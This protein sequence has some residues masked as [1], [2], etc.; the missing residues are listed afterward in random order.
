[1]YWEHAGIFGK[2]TCV[3]AK[4]EYKNENIW[5]TKDKQFALRKAPQSSYSA[6]GERARRT[7]SELIGITCG[8]EVCVCVCVSVCVCVREIYTCHTRVKSDSP[9]HC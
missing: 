3:V 9:C 2:C 5:L 6:G 7:C 8:V 1:M 4:I